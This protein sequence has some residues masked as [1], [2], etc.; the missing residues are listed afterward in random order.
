MHG[1]G[2]CVK[3]KYKSLLPP[4]SLGEGNADMY[5]QEV[6]IKALAK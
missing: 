3:C 1:F 5:R 4:L 2:Y 6:R